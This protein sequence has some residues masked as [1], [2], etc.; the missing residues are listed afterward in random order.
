MSDPTT[1][2]KAYLIL[3][4]G[5][6]DFESYL[7]TGVS[8]TDFMGVPCIKGTYRAP[9]SHWM[10]GTEMYVPLPMVRA[11]NVYPTYDAYLEALKRHSGERVPA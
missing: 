11:V 4:A 8:P 7:L 10:P 1:D 9:K 3:L 2:P 5:G 6:K